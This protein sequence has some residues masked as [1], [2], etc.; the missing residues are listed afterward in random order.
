MKNTFLFSVALILVIGLSGCGTESY[1]ENKIEREMEKSLGQNVDIDMDGDAVKIK[2]DDGFFVESGENVELPSDFPKDVYMVEGKIKSVMK[3]PVG[4]GYSVSI[5]TEKSVEDVKNIY[6][7]KLPEDGWVL[8]MQM[9]LGEMAVVS[10]T[11]DASSVSVSI[12]I[13]DE[14]TFVVLT[15]V[16]E[17]IN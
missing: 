8:N 2:T 11:K 12:T 16:T 7:E 14:K 1:M 15:V 6:T 4:G 5:E 13:Q 17:G 10:G 3:N 9:S